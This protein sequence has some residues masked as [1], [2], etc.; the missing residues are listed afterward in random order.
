MAC[1]CRVN[2]LEKLTFDQLVSVSEPKRV[3]RAKTVRGPPLDLEAY[4]DSVYYIFNFKSFPSTTGKRHKG[5]IKFFKPKSQKPLEKIECLV[6][7]TC[8]DFRYRWAWAN[9]QRGSSVVGAKSMNQSLNRAPRITNPRNRP[10]LCKH[11]LA[12]RDFVYGQYE[13]FDGQLPDASKKI[14]RIVKNVQSQTTQ[15]GK[16]VVIN[17]PDAKKNADQA[18][19]KPVNEPAKPAPKDAKGTKPQTPPVPAP[20]KPGVPADKLPKLS[21]PSSPVSGKIKPSKDA[22]PPEDKKKV[23]KPG[24]GSGTAFLDRRFNRVES[25]IRDV[26]SATFK[27]IL[28]EVDEVEVDEEASEALEILREIRDMI[29]SFTSEEEAAEAN[30]PAEDAVA[31]VDLPPPGG[32]GGGAPEE[33]PA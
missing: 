25:V 32:P 18:K 13:E 3:M 8:P 15:T 22:P 33:V 5:Y 20:G 7:C 24:S 17:K 11:L 4:D 2:I 21:I 1:F 10:G 30:P 23:P 31:D 26:N 27:E 14:E 12:M 6:D 9:K 16:P 19:K 28:E 29:R